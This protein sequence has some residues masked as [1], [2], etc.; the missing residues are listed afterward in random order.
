MAVTA[1]QIITK[2]LQKVGVLTIAE[3]PSDEEANDA[4]YQLNAML[5]S[6]SN[7]MM[8]LSARS[9]ENFTL[10]G[11][12]G[13]Y[14]I[15]TGQ[16]LN[17]VRPMFIVQSYVRSGQIDYNVTVITDENYNYIWDK[18]DTGIPVVVNYDNGYP[19]GKL[20][21]DPIPDQN[22]SLFLLTEK[23]LTSFTLDT[24][25]ILPPGW[26][27]ALIFNLGVRLSPDYA[28][29]LTDALV[30]L[31]KETKGAIRT[32]ILRNRTMDAEPFGGPIPN[33]YNGYTYGGV[34]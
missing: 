33:I 26:E 27:D 28:Q 6:W 23:P 7:D 11:G 29:P 32:A 31:A 12:T 24:D 9:W 14:T 1:R 10:S 20:R 5:S 17:T 8:L 21:F 18:Q 3:A 34:W 13:T 2:A 30:A 15:G 22:Y 16:A 19:V 4:L 25:V